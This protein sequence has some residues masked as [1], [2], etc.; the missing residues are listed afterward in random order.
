M[1]FG[2]SISRLAF[3]MKGD[4][5]EKLIV[6]KHIVTLAD[7]ERQKAEFQKSTP[8]FITWLFEDP[9]YS[10]KLLAG[11]PIDRPRKNI[12]KQS[13]SIL[14]RSFF[15]TDPVSMSSYYHAFVFDI[16][17]KDLVPIVDGPLKLLIPMGIIDDLENA[18]I[19]MADDLQDIVEKIAAQYMRHREKAW[20]EKW[21]AAEE[22]SG[23]VVAGAY[24][25]DLDW[26]L[27][28]YVHLETNGILEAIKK[29]EKIVSLELSG[30]APD[31]GI[32]NQ[33]R[34][35]IESL[36]NELERRK[37]VKLPDGT[38]LKVKKALGIVKPIDLTYEQA[39]MIIGALNFADGEGVS[40]LEGVLRLGLEE[41]DSL[42]GDMVSQLIEKFPQL[43]ELRL[44]LINKS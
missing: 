17:T 44:W 35:S 15:A 12:S 8:D 32:V 36:K 1:T 28:P 4:P 40:G 43:K 11:E 14:K 22:E 7:E 13:C 5:S 33:A 41:Y 27:R 10:R 16:N 29:K 18:G 9:E 20:I 34:Q 25:P 38:G 21:S 39:A 26:G 19:A 24:F 2:K 37:E 30:P 3:Y 23:P 31:L 6:G 42:R